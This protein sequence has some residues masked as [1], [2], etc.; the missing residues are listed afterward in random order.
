MFP[1]H[2]GDEG[3]RLPRKPRECHLFP[4][5]QL[6]SPSLC[7]LKK[8]NLGR[9][10]LENISRVLVSRGTYYWDRETL[11]S[12]SYGFRVTGLISC[13]LRVRIPNKGRTK[14]EQRGVFAIWRLIGK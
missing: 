13:P 9:R 3:H 8:S 11:M 4:K 7:S 2:F 10:V 5:I 12:P 14:I 6:K 1:G